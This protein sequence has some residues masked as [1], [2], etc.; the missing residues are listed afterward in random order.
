LGK[1]YEELKWDKDYRLKDAYLL[2]DNLEITEDPKNEQQSQ[3]NRWKMA[4]SVPN[5]DHWRDCYY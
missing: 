3:K 5:T 2:Y 4:F 1:T